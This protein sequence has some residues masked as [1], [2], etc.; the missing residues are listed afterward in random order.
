MKKTI[1]FI[2]LTL[3]LCTGCSKNASGSAHSSS[4]SISSS[5]SSSSSA[6]PETDYAAQY[7]SQ[8]Q[9]ADSLLGVL[10]LGSYPVGS[11][12]KQALAGSGLTQKLPF[13]DELPDSQ[14]VIADNA[15]HLFLLVPAEHTSM[16]IYHFSG[17]GTD[18]LAY[19]SP[20]NSIV[21]IGVD[22]YGQ[23]PSFEVKVDGLS[24]RTLDWIISGNPNTGEIG[25]PDSGITQLALPM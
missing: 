25:Y 8:V 19:T 13:L 5:A 10:D 18:R 15:S 7:L 16:N 21:L 3:F 20:D 12:V 17:S 24:K 22:L 9:Q 11:D 23:F 4:A 2:L 14:I 6:E 1:L